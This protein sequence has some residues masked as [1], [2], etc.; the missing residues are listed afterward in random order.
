MSDCWGCVWQASGGTSGEHAAERGGERSV[1]VPA[2]RGGARPSGGAVCA[3]PRLLQGKRV[4][5]IAKGHQTHTHSLTI[6]YSDTST[7]GVTSQAMT[8]I[9]CLKVG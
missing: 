8:D 1:P 2:V 5:H 7:Q 6:G 3:V 9:V 4:C